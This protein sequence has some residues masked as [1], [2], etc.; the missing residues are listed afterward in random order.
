MTLNSEQ[1]RQ[2][3]AVA[4]H[5]KPVIIVGDK[6]VSEAL[7]TELDRALEDHELIK[8]KLASNDRELRQAMVQQ[9]TEASRAELVQ[10]IGKIAVLLRRAQKPNPKLS[11]LLR[12]QPGA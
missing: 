2:F 6:G 8:V 9:L 7:L 1:R 10:M 5:L 4:H 3:R 12:Q 11:N